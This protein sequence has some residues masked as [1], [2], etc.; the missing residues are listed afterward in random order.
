[1]RSSNTKPKPLKLHRN[2]PLQI[3]TFLYILTWSTLSLSYLR[4]YSGHFGVIVLYESIHFS[5]VSFL[6][7]MVIPCMQT[8]IRR[9]YIH[10]RFAVEHSYSDFLQQYGSTDHAS[11]ELLF[12]KQRLELR[13]ALVAGIST[14]LLE[15]TSTL[16]WFSVLFMHQSTVTCTIPYYSRDVQPATR[17]EERLRGLPVAS[18]VEKS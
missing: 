4:F 5:Q 14:S 12:T 9:L 3:L 7:I 11:V 10:T 17:E 1:M 6:N 18:N 13:A 15:R 16:L 2:I 8:S